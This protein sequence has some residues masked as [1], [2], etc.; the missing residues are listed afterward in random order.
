MHPPTSDRS[1]RRVRL[2]LALL[3][4]ALSTFTLTTACD[5]QPKPD[6]PPA[7]RADLAE[8]PTPDPLFARVGGRWKGEELCLE[9]FA[10]GDFELSDM[11]HREGPKVLVMGRT[12][13]RA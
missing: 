12:A 8:A 10:N 7:D 6:A 1:S 3:A 11:R 13:H 4:L 5:A 2:A 9:L